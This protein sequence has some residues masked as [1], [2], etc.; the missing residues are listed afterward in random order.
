MLNVGLTGGIASGK[1]TVARMFAT[2]GAILIDFDTLAHDVEKPDGPVWTGI[3]SHFGEGILR[4]DRKIDRRKLGDIVFADR[5]KRELLNRLVHPAVFD[6]WRRRLASI[7]NNRADAV[8]LSDIPLLIEAGMKG[9]VDLVLLIYIPREEQ[10]RRLMERNGLTREEAEKR[11]AA[12]M[13]IDEKIPEADVVIGNE[14][15]LEETERQVDRVW[16]TLCLRAG[17]EDGP[18]M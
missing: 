17:I 8:V 5:E 10:I 6:E 3:V 12:Q 7:G 13:P 11:I 9:M 1:S 4:P 18:A 16:K 15:S 2:K 14:G